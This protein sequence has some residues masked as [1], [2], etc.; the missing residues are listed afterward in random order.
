MCAH[1]HTCAYTRRHT[2]ALTENRQCVGP[3][4]RGNLRR[5][6]LFPRPA[7]VFGGDGQSCWRG[8]VRLRGDPAQETPARLHSNPLKP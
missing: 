1:T 3:G 7:A 4:Y 6:L 5:V 2:R 8:N